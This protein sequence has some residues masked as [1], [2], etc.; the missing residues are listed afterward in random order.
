VSEDKAIREVR[1]RRIW[2]NSH[3]SCWS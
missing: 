1:E 3:S 2:F